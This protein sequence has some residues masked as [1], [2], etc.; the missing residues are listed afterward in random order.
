MPM[1]CNARTRS[2]CEWRCCSHYAQSERKQ[3]RR[4]IKR[5]Q[6]QSVK[7]LTREPWRW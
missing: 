2:G 4:A 1:T 7:R 5:R 6:K 3:E